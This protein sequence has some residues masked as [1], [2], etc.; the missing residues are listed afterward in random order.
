MRANAYAHWPIN[1]WSASERP[2]LGRSEGARLPLRRA[3]CPE[4][5]GRGAPTGTPG[6]SLALLT[7]FFEGRKKGNGGPGRRN[8]RDE[9]LCLVE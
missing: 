4:L 2:P 1:T 5:A 9:K 3:P 8:S 6:R 7:F